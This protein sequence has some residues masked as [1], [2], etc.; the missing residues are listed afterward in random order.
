MDTVFNFLNSIFYWIQAFEKSNLVF[1]LKILAV[2]ISIVLII[3]IINLA[4][5]A[6]IIKNQ[7]IKYRTFWEAAKYEKK[8]TL[9]IWKKIIKLL[10]EHDEASRKEAVVLADKL[11][12]EMLER[13]GWAGQNLDEMLEKTTAAQLAN[14]ES[15][16]TSHN[17]VKKIISEPALLLTHNEAIQILL[18]YEKAFRDFGLIED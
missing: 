9:R 16:K 12:E 14:L 3:I 6:N 8:H 15:I 4:I 13:S 2:L 7:I 1:G 5:K 11:L 10:K 18:S 17:M